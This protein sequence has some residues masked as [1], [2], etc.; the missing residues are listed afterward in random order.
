M[1]VKGQRGLI[2]DLVGEPPG[3]LKDVH[4]FHISFISTNSTVPIQ[5]SARTL[6]RTYTAKRLNEKSI[7]KGALSHLAHSAYTLN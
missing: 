3:N 1:N 4:I 5:G 2:C 6:Y 7:Q